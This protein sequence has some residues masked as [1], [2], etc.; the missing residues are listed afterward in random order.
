MQPPEGFMIKE[1]LPIDASSIQQISHG[2]VTDESGL[3]AN[4]FGAVNTHSTIQNESVKALVT[5]RAR[6]ARSG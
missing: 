5:H 4:A 3:T 2:C 1:H 6:K